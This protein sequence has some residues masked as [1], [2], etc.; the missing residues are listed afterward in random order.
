MQL[1]RAATAAA[2][3]LAATG[4]GATTASAATAA[5]SVTGVSPAIGLVAGGTRVTVTGTGFSHV[6]AVRFGTAS[7]SSLRVLSTTSLQ[8]TSPP[9]DT[10]QVHITVQT[11][12]GTSARRSADLYTFRHRPNGVRALSLTDRTATTT[13]LRWM[14]SPDT[15]LARIEVHRAT[16][17]TPPAAPTS[18][19]LVAS[20]PTAQTVFTD[21]GLAAATK[22][23]WAVFTVTTAGALASAPKSVTAKTTSTAR[24]TAPTGLTTQYQDAASCASPD[25]FTRGYDLDTLTIAAHLADPDA[26]SALLSLH[27]ALVDYGPT[28]SGDPVRLIKASQ[29]QYWSARTVSGTGGDV[30][31]RLYGIDFVEGH[32][33]G[34]YVLASD[35]THI[36]APSATCRFWMDSVAPTQPAV[37]GDFPPDGVARVGSPATFT[38]SAN[39]V[40]PTDGQY[41][42]I[43][44]FGYSFGSC[45]EL[46]D[47]GGTHVPVSPEGT[48]GTATIAFTPTVWGTN[49]LCVDA[50]DAAGNASA[51]TTYQFYVVG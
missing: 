4:V 25:A 47:D 48:Q 7:G 9:H 32:Q 21:T 50:I 11:S 10:S 15:D 33:Y 24:P 41:A 30:S 16:G 1:R 19:T 3:L 31:T 36:S 29:S 40:A 8:V 20:L 34:I 23:A 13:V 28:G 39:D 5:P 2:L 17:R 46:S 51:S 42:H 27:P 14:S 6:V 49:Y 43:D 35:G 12:A 26:P 37:T 44:H 18:D 45:S 22:Y 38:M